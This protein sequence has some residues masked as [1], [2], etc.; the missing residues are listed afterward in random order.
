M[1]EANTLPSSVFRAPIALIEPSPPAGPWPMGGRG[2]RGGRC[3]SWERRSS[4]PPRIRN[5]SVHLRR[6]RT[7]DENGD[8]G[9]RHRLARCGFPDP[10][11]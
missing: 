7:G 9:G 1:Y 11:G 10:T 8:P 3:P 6:R 2:A 4:S 5:P